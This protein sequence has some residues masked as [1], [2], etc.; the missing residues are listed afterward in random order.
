MKT[1]WANSGRNDLH[2]FSAGTHARQ[3]MRA[4]QEAIDVCAEHDIDIQAHRTSPVTADIVRR[5]DAIYA[6]EAVQIDFMKLFYP[7]VV[8]K[9][10]LLAQWSPESKIK[11]QMVIEDPI[12]APVSEY[13]RAFDRIAGCVDALLPQL[14]QWAA[15]DS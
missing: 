13:R 7:E 8:E 2:V 9:A 11:K 4:A 14:T 3:G 5:A 6:M 10:C 12:G 15:T 1:R